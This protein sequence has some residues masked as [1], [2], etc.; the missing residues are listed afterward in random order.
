MNQIFEKYKYKIREI[1]EEFL[2]RIYLEV[3]SSIY[4]E[5][6]AYTS[7]DSNY[8]RPILTLLG[9]NYMLDSSPL[10]ESCQDQELLVIPQIIRDVLAIHDDIIDEDLTKFQHDTLP[11]SLSKMFSQN[12]QNM[13]KEGKDFALL[14]GDYLYPKIYSIVLNCNS[15]FKVK[16]SMLECINDVM[17]STNIGQLEELLMQYRTLDEFSPDDILRMYKRKAANYC[18]AFPFSLGA[19]YAGIS[20]ETL[21]NT[22]EILLEI[23]AASQVVD[24]LMGIFPEV[25]GETKSTL[26][27]LILLR[28]SY[29]MLVLYDC[30]REDTKLQRILSL[31]SCTEEQARMIKEK[32]ISTGTLTQ[33]VNSLKRR[34]LELDKEID[35]LD[36]GCYCRDYFKELIKS[37]IVSNLDCVIAFFYGE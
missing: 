32:M 35:E 7:L 17:E 27:D 16:A 36:L 15:S 37:R 22:R 19:I 26:S 33:V 8:P 1:H 4:Q 34:C 12:P 2:N 25:L 14:F 20:D 3:D 21:R 10:I 6:R 31:P 9:M 29:L 13:N 11:F 30:S 28:R 18:Y 23:G 24:D 5:Y